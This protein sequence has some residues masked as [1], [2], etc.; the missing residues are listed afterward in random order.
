MA[1]TV[2]HLSII[3]TIERILVFFFSSFLDTPFPSLSGKTGEH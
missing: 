1:D 2:I 3:F